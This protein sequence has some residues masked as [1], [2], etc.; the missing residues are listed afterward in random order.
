LLEVA[1]AEG[2]IILKWILKK[3]DGRRCITF[4]ICLITQNRCG[5][6]DTQLCK[7]GVS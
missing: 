4:F 2:R 1:S 6:L 5:L 3:Q 7:F